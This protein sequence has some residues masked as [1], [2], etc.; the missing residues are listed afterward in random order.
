MKRLLIPLLLLASTV[1]AAETKPKWQKINQ[2]GQP[3][4]IKLGPWHCAKDNT[5]ELTWEVKSWHETAHYYKA[6]YSYYDPLTK[7]GVIDGGSCQQGN[8]WYP[9]D[10]SD[11]IETLNKQAYCGITTW[12]LPTLA[13]LKTLI[14]RDNIKGK[15]LINGYIFPRNTKS[16]YMTADT[17]Q[18]NGQ[19]KITMMDFWREQVQ[20]RNA[21]VVAN[22]RLV[23]D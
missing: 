20:Q 14:Y 10:V 12:R 5:T 3:V 6:T 13:E 18:I 9:C 2:Q 16:I 1:N 4:G 17:S 22:V 7:Q 23:A 11:H 15:L 21:D 8:E 19:L